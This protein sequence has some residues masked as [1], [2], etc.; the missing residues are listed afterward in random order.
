VANAIIHMCYPRLHPHPVCT[1]VTAEEMIGAHATTAHT[2]YG[3]AL[4]S[5]YAA[6]LAQCVCDAKDVQQALAAF[7][8]GDFA[9]LKAVVMASVG[10]SQIE[11]D[12]HSGRACRIPD[13]GLPESSDTRLIARRS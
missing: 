13:Q 2:G 6:V 11:Q 5:E 9:V 8:N 1:P 4:A 7:V 12:R 10:V 3:G